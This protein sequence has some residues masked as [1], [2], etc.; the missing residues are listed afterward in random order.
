MTDDDDPMAGVDA[1]E[2][3]S[4]ETTAEVSVWNIAPDELFGIDR[5]HGD[6]EVLD[7]E[8]VGD[9]GD[10]TIRV[11]YEAQLE[12]KPK[13]AIRKRS[14][15]EQR[16]DLPWHKRNA[17]R[18]IGAALGG[19]LALGVGT[20]LTNLFGDMTINGEPFGEPS[21][22]EILAPVAVLFLLVWL[23][24]YAAVVGPRGM[25]Q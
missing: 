19:G 12:K 21:L 5:E 2:T 16:Q 8:V 9:A 6:R 18:I 15:R 11:T 10:E 1:G 4:F 20:A 7:A 24:G 22:I 17:H 14:Q 3:V 23:I 13:P 25:F